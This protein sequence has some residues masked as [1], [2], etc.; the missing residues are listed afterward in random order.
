MEKIAENAALKLG[1]RMAMLFFSVVVGPLAVWWLISINNGV[2][3]IKT[4]LAVQMQ[5]DKDQERRLTSLER[6][7]SRWYSP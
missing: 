2:Q 7:F 6:I 5:V 4:G 3:E 1:A